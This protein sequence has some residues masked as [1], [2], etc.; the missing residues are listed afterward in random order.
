LISS[1]QSSVHPHFQD[2]IEAYRA[3]GRPSFSQVSPTEARELLRRSIVI[4]RANQIPLALASVTDHVIPGPNGP[5]RIRR[6]RPHGV[7]NGTCVYFHAGGWVIGD[8]EMSDPLCRL[9]AAEAHCEIVS[10]EYRL[11]P[12]YPYPAPLNDAYAA[13]Q[14]AALHCS[15]PLMVAG[16]SAGGNLAAACA[17]RA[18]DCAGPSIRGQFLAY[19]VMDADFTTSSYQECG[20]RGWLLS[21]QDMQWFWNHYC[22][23]EVDRTHP[24]I[25]PL[26]VQSAAGLPPMLVFAAECDPLRD[27]ALAYAALLSRA[28]V[29]VRTRCDPGMLHGYLNAMSAIPLAAEAAS[30]AAAWIRQRLDNEEQ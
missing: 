30:E 13:V 29:P 28:G 16:E 12:E 1:R 18:R 27:E 23:P 4:A 24:L 5:L 17:I 25:S 6:Y 7:W 9:L 20:D 8:L 22:P 21:T 19:P 14:W 26:R 11:A 2:I 3:S 15:S 10:V